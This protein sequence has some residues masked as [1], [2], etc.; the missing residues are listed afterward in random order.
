MKRVMR[1]LRTTAIIASLLLCV[2]LLLLW[3]RS[4]K[5][6]TGVN[7]DRG[8]S[9][10]QVRSAEGV[11]AIQRSQLPTVPPLHAFSFWTQPKPTP[12]DWTRVP[13]GVIGIVT[14]EMSFWDRYWW[15]PKPLFRRWGF[16]AY[17]SAETRFGDWY[18]DP[19]TPGCWAVETPYWFG[20]ALTAVAP[21]RWAARTQVR[22]HRRRRRLCAACAYDLRTTP[23][24]CPECGRDARSNKG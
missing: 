14:D 9:A 24:R 21:L 1:I 4:H 3:V 11:L 6:W 8:T 22:R 15:K 16:A 10:F 12:F 23:N 17:R 2:T 13:E 19:A 5:R 18:V 7:W 20:V